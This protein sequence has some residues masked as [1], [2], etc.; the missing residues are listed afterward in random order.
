MAESQEA[1]EPDDEAAGEETKAKEKKAKGTSRDDQLADVD[2]YSKPL[3]D[4]RAKVEKAFMDQVTRVND[5]ADYWDI[6]ECI[7]NDNQAYNG[8]SAC[9]IALVADA[10]DARQTRFCNQLFPLNGRYVEVVTENGDIPHAEMALIEHYIDK[11]KMKTM[12]AAPLCRNGDIEGQYNIYVSW[13]EQTRHV[14]KHVTEDGVESVVEEEIVDSQPEIE[15]IPDADVAIF[16]ATSNTVLSALEKGGGVAITRRWTKAKIEQMAED[17]EIT[18]DAADSINAQMDSAANGTLQKD[19]AKEHAAAAGIRGKGEY[20]VARE[21][22]HKL[23]VD[24]KMR[25]VKSYFGCDTVEKLG[26]KLNPLWC[27]RVPLISAPVKKL[28]GVAKGSSLLKRVAPIQYAANDFLNEALDSATYSLL[29]I[30]MT[31]PNSNPKTSTMILDLAAVWEVDPKKTQFAAFP[32]LW[33][34]GFEL[35]ASLKAQVQQSLSVNP[36]MIPMNHG[37]RKPNQAE[38][39]NEQQVDVLTTAEAVGVLEEGVFTPAVELIVEMDMQYRHDDLLV[40]QFG[41]MGRRA[42]LERIPPLQ[43]GQR[44]KFKWLGVQAMRNAAAVQQQIGMVNVVKGIP[45]QLMPNHRLDLTAVV[46][47]LVETTMGPRLAPLTFVD[48][49]ED[50]SIKPE[51]ENEMLV[52]GFDVRTSP[53]DDDQKHIQVHMQALEADTQ[54]HV[55]AHI[56]RHQQAIQ[57]K[58]VM[59]M[60]EKMQQQ[61]GGQ[62]PGPREGA[63][64]GAQRPAQGPP[65]QIPP[66]KMT[67]QGGGVVQMPRK[68]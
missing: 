60:Q 1:A 51:E 43:M 15:V 7:L 38:V 50:L 65:G 64:P 44:Y 39:A 24:G 12:I 13:S 42:K 66:D 32:P 30:T 56:Q 29:P 54:G 28:S 20:Y 17:G 67:G 18:Q 8:N 63:Q 55:M 47:N 4:I 9:Y 49:R 31:D 6:Y 52:Q 26:T 40:P 27:D 33:Q 3:S 35:I 14:I 46:E 37:K 57:I 36:S 10:I 21:V 53:F 59:A 61:G 2:S 11:L 48:L 22:W 5:H 58:S 25:I 34:H 68:M 16:P 23:K 62:G 41:M 45:P 19:M